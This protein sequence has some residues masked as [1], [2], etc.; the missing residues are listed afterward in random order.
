MRLLRNLP[1]IQSMKTAR[2]SK[3]GPETE[4]YPIRTVAT[5]TGVNPVTLRAWERRYG[6]IA[7]MRTGG[8]HRLYSRADIDAIHRIVAAVGG[9]ASIGRMPRPA[10]APAR[11]SAKARS[12]GVWATCRQ[13]MADAIAQFDEMRLAQIHDDALAVHSTGAVTRNVLMPLLAMQGERWR[14]SDAGI[15]EE[16]FLGVYL[17]N[18][19]GARFHHRSGAPQGP[20]LLAACL[21]GERHETGL[22]L[23]GLAAHDRGFRV[24]MLGADMPLAQ[25]APAARHARAAAIVLSCTVAPDPATLSHDL[26]KL[27]DDVALPVFVGGSASVRLR[28]AIVSAGMHPLGD[29]IDAALTHIESTLADETAS[30]AKEKR[31]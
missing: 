31:R 11:T 7:P 1:G 16:H 14:T 3:Q 4:L 13:A 26:R 20:K 24:V 19:I 10:A 17:R 8:G 28:D 29:D 23:F 30:R 21:P 15:A 27:V 2:A 5:L 6:L 12:A 18:K 25:L 22:L 9:G